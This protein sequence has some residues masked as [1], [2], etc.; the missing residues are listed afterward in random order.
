MIFVISTPVLDRRIN[1]LRPTGGVI[2]PIS[3]QRVETTPIHIGSNPITFVNASNTNGIVRITILP[4]SIR[5]PRTNQ[6]MNSRI[7]IVQRLT[8]LAA[9]ADARPWAIP[10]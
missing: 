3:T 5:Q 10:R 8:P 2:I 7:I 1:R 4:G 6:R 9:I